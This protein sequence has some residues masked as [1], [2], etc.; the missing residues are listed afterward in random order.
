MHRTGGIIINE[1]FENQNFNICLKGNRFCAIIESE[2]INNIYYC[3]LL[4]F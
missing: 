3:I 1:G 2:K 4:L